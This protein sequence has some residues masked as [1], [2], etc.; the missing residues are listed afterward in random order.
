[1]T[2]ILQDATAWLA[3]SF[4]I[5]AWVLWTYGKGPFLALIDSYI[6]RAR[7]ELEEARRLREE[8]EILLTRYEADYQNALKESEQIVARTKKHVDD[9]QAQ[10]ERDLAEISARHERQ[11]E[12]RLDRMKVAAVE[13]IQNYAAD[14]AVNAAREIILAK[15]DNKSQGALIE[16]SIAGARQN[17]N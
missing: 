14:L 7:N 9:M 11:L 13:E 1:M 3:L 10:A 2:D 8:A 16:K 4:A 6:E 12:A 17:L 5:F 15:L